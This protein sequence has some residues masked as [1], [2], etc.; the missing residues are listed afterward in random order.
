[1]RDF[2]EWHG[3]NEDVIKLNHLSYTIANLNS[4]DSEINEPISNLWEVDFYLP[5]P[6]KN[7]ALSQ[8]TKSQTI[9]QELSD[10][11][12]DEVTDEA[13]MAVLK[14][15]IVLSAVG[16][17]ILQNHHPHSDYKVRISDG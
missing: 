4:T 6:I 5:N 13:S 15:N 10:Q 16:T 3:K 9:T 1:M 14:S 7:R 17:E 11:I 8:F 2:Q 12:P